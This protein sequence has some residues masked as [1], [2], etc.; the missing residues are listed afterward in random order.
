MDI[1]KVTNLNFTCKQ[2]LPNSRYSFMNL[3]SIQTGLS[4]FHHLTFTVLKTK[5]SRSEPKNNII[6]VYSL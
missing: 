6:F 3:D 1:I 5:F 2:P 4:D